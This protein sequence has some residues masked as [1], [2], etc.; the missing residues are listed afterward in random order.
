MVTFTRTRVENLERLSLSEF[1][2]F[3]NVTARACVCVRSPWLQVDPH[4]L[5][6]NFHS[7]D[8]WISG[9]AAIT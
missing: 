2:V 4:I 9:V 6:G 1:D 3:D 8:E 5:R 7:A